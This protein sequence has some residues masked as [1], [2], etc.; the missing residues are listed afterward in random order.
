MWVLYACMQC[1]WRHCSPF[2]VTLHRNG[3]P[4]AASGGRALLLAACR[5]RE[6]QQLHL[7]CWDGRNPLGEC[8]NC[9][10]PPSP[11]SPQ[12][13]GDVCVFHPHAII[14]FCPSLPSA[15]E[16][17]HCPGHTFCVVLGHSLL[18][19]VA[20]ILKVSIPTGGGQGWRRG[21]GLSL[22]RTPPKSSSCREGRGGCQAGMM[23]HSGNPRSTIARA[24][25]HFWIPASLYEPPRTSET[26]T[27]SSGLSWGRLTLKTSWRPTSLPTAHMEK[28]LMAG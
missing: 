28:L 23:N 5:I 17:Q 6:P 15:L 18:W 8:V 9:L 1:L 3:Q 10:P 16:T 14:P 12:H 7:S 22:K 13:S 27:V 26:F 2:C 11:C 24:V 21:K 4:P 19:T 25:P 20:T